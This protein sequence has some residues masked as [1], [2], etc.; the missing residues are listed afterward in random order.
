[1]ATVLSS[2]TGYF[3]FFNPANTEVVVKVLDACAVDGHF[4][5]FG[6]G[7]TNL[8]VTLTVTDLKTGTTATYTNTDGSPFQPIQDFATFLACN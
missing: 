1:M 2:D 8:G 4:W 7:L 3:W 6:S 5:I